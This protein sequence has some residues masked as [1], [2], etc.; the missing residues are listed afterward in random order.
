MNA[1]IT[2]PLRARIASIATMEVVAPDVKPER[3]KDSTIGIPVKSNFRYGS[4]G[5]TTLK[6]ENFM[7]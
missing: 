4:H 2:S 5:K 7:A 3:K 6:P 1:L